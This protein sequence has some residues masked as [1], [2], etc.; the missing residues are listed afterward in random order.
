MSGRAATEVSSPGF[1]LLEGSDLQVQ[2]PVGYNTSESFCLFSC[3]FGNMCFPRNL[4]VSSNFLNTLL[5]SRVEC[6]LTAILCRMSLHLA[7]LSGC[8]SLGP[9]SW[10][11]LSLWALL[12]VCFVHVTSL[13]S[14]SLPLLPLGLVYASSPSFLRCSLRPSIFGLSSCVREF[15]YN[16]NNVLLGNL[17]K[18][19]GKL[20]QFLS[21]LRNCSFLF[22]L[23][24]QWYN[25]LE[26]VLYKLS[27][28]WRKCVDCVL[29][30]FTSPSVISECFPGASLLSS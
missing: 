6:P 21:K 16:W 17:V 14:P 20:F 13:L 9:A 30:S 28:Y 8:L 1:A 5:W 19:L 11:L 2:P 10:E 29:L 25:F 27:K 3:Q 26:L 7:W 15:A 18:L 24:Q 4:S 22:L 23:G 12:T